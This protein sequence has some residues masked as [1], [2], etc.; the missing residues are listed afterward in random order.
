MLKEKNNIFETLEQNCCFD[1]QF[2]QDI[3]HERVGSPT[4]YRWKVQFIVTLPKEK[5]KELKKIKNVLVCGSITTDKNQARLSVQKQE[6][7]NSLI[8][9]FFTKN[10]LNGV[11]KKDFELWQKAVSVILANKRKPITKW[12]KSELLSLFHIH[13]SIAKY[14]N[15]PRQAKWMEMAK[16]IANIPC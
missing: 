4:Y 16:T 7:I 3:R 5:I 11:K 12:K 6:D 2:R 9:P 1:L 10:K 14:K 8:L 13:K 15:H